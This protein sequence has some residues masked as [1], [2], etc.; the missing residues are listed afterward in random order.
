[1]KA[2]S[3]FACGG[4]GL[5]LLGALRDP[6][7][8]PAVRR[9][10]AEHPGE[11]AIPGYNVTTRPAED[12]LRAL[13]LGPVSGDAQ[14]LV[15]LAHQCLAHA[16]AVTLGPWDNWLLWGLGWF[17]DDFRLTQD[18]RRLAA[19]GRGICSD[20]VIVLLAL[21]Q[22]AQTPSRMVGLYGHVVAELE[23]AEGWRVADPDF[24]ILFPFDRATLSKPEGLEH[25]REELR[26]RGHGEEV[27]AAYIDAAS[28]PDDVEILPA[29]VL[30]PRLARLEQVAEWLEWILPLGG[31]WLL[32]R[33]RR[34]TCPCRN[35]R[36]PRNTAP[37]PANSS[38]TEAA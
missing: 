11:Q 12:L 3:W 20:A 31:L 28:S 37:R 14:S 2:R 27:V 23:T 26:L 19:G 10:H 17:N 32:V 36:A 8:G 38:E 34:R 16:E 6:V 15:L 24:G 4:L 18:A 25:I 30:S 35:H 1:V 5:L 21:A 7:L 33:R 29:G 9:H 13:D 22:R